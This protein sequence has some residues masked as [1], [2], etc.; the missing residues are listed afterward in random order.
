MGD[1][2]CGPDHLA[3]FPVV[4]AREDWTLVMIK[5]LHNSKPESGILSLY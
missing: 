1:Q 4:G 2:R 3:C 5:E